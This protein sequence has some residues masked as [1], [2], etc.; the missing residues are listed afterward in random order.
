[1]IVKLKNVPICFPAVFSPQA[2]GDGNPAYG[3]KFPIE[4]GSNNA[5]LLDE[6][7][8]AEAKEKWKDKADAVLGMLREDKRVAYVHAPYRNKGTGEVYDGFVDM[9][10][11]SCRSEKTR[12]SV[13][14]KDGVTQVSEA[15]G[16]IHSGAIVNAFVEVYAFDSPKWGKR[17]N[18]TLTGI[19]YVDQGVAFGGSAPVAAGAF[20][21]VADDEE[22]V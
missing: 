22:F 4:P 21:A 10:A 8:T 11:L 13:F 1:M 19:Q 18:C 17:I 2:Y 5:K 20:E 6:A 7:V 15:D 9:F 16:L 14:N 12:P 3:A